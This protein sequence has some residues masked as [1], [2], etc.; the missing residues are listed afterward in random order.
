LGALVLIAYTNFL[1]VFVAGFGFFVYVVLYSLWK[2]RTIYGTAIGSMAGAVPP[3]VGYCAASNRLDM[4]AFILFTML[5]LWQ[6][7]H[8]LSIAVINL[9]DYAAANIPV[10]PVKK[11]IFRTKIHM[12]L[13]ISAFI[14][15]TMLLTFF[16][17]T[18][19]KYLMI[20]AIIGLGWLLL[21]AKGFKSSDDQAWGCHMFRL[22]LVMIGAICLAIPLDVYD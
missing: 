7:P 20:A 19:F 13:Y 2:C 1:A 21:C 10:L 4:G 11:G 3:V 15:V 5:V 12:M 17:Y 14:F 8:F 16:N 6:M 9:E 18:G 22:S